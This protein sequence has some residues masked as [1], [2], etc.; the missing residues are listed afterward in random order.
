MKINISS[1]TNNSSYTVCTGTVKNT[2]KKTYR[3][4]EVKG[5][6]KDS[7]NNVVDTDWTYAAGSEGLAPGESSSFRLSVPK[8]VS[9]KSC[10][11][12]LL[13]YE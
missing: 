13:D 7:S 2:G 1:V 11:V 10:S 12:S 9:I 6:F 5:S 4:V 8:N 3:Y